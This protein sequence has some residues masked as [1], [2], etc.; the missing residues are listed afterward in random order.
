MVN[1]YYNTLQLQQRASLHLMTSNKLQPVIS[2]DE[3]YAEHSRQVSEYP[4]EGMMNYLY[5]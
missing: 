3:E 5:T 2:N 4:A 1:D